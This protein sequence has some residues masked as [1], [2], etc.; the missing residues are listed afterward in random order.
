MLEV[1]EHIRGGALDRSSS[2]E[3]LL[4]FLTCTL[5]EGVKAG[6]KFKDLIF[7]SY[8]ETPITSV[9]RHLL[10]YNDRNIFN[11][12]RNTQL[13]GNKAITGD[14]NLWSLSCICILIYRYA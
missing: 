4:N 14:D 5:L 9:S 6:T 2:R 1:V 7:E 11:L 13:A 12:D 3:R 10:W 8:E